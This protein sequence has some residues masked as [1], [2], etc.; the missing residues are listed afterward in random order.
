[1]QTSTAALRNFPSTEDADLDDLADEML[2]QQFAQGDAGA[3]DV[4]YERHRAP[5]FRFLLRQCGNRAQSEELFQDVWMSLVGARERYRVE[6]K[7]TTYLYTMARHRVIDHYRRQGVR[8]SHEVPDD[9]SAIE[10]APAADAVLDEQ[11]D[12]RRSVS[13][14]LRL[15]EDLP[16]AQREVILLRA[17]QGLS[18]EEIAQITSS[19][20]ETVK[21]RLRYALEKLKRGM[22]GLL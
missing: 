21:S 4:L 12:S 9:E 14:L 11:L 17:E 15:V 10:S 18:L 1:M 16:S 6:A 20:R 5:L 22:E 8:S 19:E 2:M 13:R 3:F 7:F